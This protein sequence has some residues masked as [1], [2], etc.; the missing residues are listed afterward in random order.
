MSTFFSVCLYV[1][2]ACLF[3]CLCLV[4]FWVSSITTRLFVCLFVCLF[5]ITNY[6]MHLDTDIYNVHVQ[7]ICSIYMYNLY[8]YV[9]DYDLGICVI[10]RLHCTIRKSIDWWLVYRLVTSTCIYRLVC[11][12]QI[13]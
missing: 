13:T 10:C 5:L 3:I 2:Y 12:L 8:M 7:C 4:E 9:Y 1:Q 6:I 11:D